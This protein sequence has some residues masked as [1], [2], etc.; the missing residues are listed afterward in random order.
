MSISRIDWSISSEDWIEFHLQQLLC[1][2]TIPN[3]HPATLIP[4]FFAGLTS[5]GLYQSAGHSMWWIPRLTDPDRSI[6]T[7]PLVHQPVKPFPNVSDLMT[8]AASV[9][10]HSSVLRS[11]SAL[12][13]RAG[14]WQKHYDTYSITGQTKSENRSL[15]PPQRKHN[16]TRSF[17]VK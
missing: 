15:S 17:Q 12:H 9:L 14:E 16:H 1:A 13:R 5:T 6:G 7:S 10:L 8:G 2:G 11:S 3:R 4:T